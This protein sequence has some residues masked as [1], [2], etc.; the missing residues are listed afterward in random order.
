MANVEYSGDIQEIEL[1]IILNL[2]N[3]IQFIQLLNYLIFAFSFKCRAT[4]FFDICIKL[5]LLIES[6]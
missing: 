5:F 1:S 4:K 2:E 3:R 6:N